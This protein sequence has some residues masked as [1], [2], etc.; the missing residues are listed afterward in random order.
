MAGSATSIEARGFYDYNN[1]YEVFRESLLYKLRAWSGWSHVQ[2]FFDAGFD[3][4]AWA[5]YSK[6]HEPWY[7]D[8]LP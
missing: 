2:V 8:P 5:D 4:K 1:R 3:E 6:E 7:Y